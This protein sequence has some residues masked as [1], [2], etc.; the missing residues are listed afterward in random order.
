MFRRGFI[1]TV[2][3]SIAGF[4]ALLTS[5][6]P[7]G[8]P[9]GVRAQALGNTERPTTPPPYPRI[10]MVS[11]VRVTG[12]KQTVAGVSYID[13]SDLG[14]CERDCAILYDVYK[15]NHKGAD[16]HCLGRNKKP[17]RARYSCTQYEPGHWG[18]LMTLPCGKKLLDVMDEMPSMAT[19]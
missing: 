1:G 4:F 5:G 11:V 2:L 16:E 3:A 15:L 8:L 12:T 9:H 13:S 18:L 10:E 14:D 17:I 6:V 7:K 19:C